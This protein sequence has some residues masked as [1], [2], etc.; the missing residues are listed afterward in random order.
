MSKFDKYF[1]WF[2]FFY[3]ILKFISIK[4]TNLNLYGDEAQY[5]LWSK[6]FSFGYFS[7]PPL[8]SWL[9][10]G[11][12]NFFGNSFFTLKSIPILIYC[13]TSYF[14]YLLVIKLYN[15]KDLAITCAIT[16]FLLPA[17][18]FSSFLL[19]TD[20]ILIF[21]WVLG[22]IQLVKIKEKQG[23]FNFFILG[24]ILGCSL[25]SK[26]AG[27]YFLLGVFCLIIFENNFK[28]I[29]LKNKFKF[30][31]TIIIMMIVISPNLYWNYQNEWLTFGHTADNASLEKISL[32]FT[33][34]I[35]FFFAQIIM[36]GP[37]LF[38]CFCFYFFKNFNLNSNEKL[39]LCFAAPPL[40]IVGIE[41]LIVRA[42]ANWAA[43]SL[44][45]FSILCVCM[46]YKF[47]KKLI[48]INNI[49]NIIVGVIL[50]I[51]ISVDYD[52]RLFD[53]IS[54]FKKFVE[55]VDT[56]N[57]TKINNIVVSDRLLFASLSYEYYSKNINL[58]STR[59]PEE[60]I[61]HHFQIN[62]FLPKDFN[63]SFLLIGN[64][65]NINYLEN[66]YNVELVGSK[67]F[68]FSKEKIKLYE[69]ILN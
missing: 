63:K 40:I 16:F 55:F 58:Y 28:L 11:I 19:S 52:S 30:F 46:I 68:P 25:L 47:N 24:L 9:I 42:H 21:F 60:K 18:S 49:I 65:V 32:N 31:F 22:L 10:G 26:Y 3:L 1:F 33:G 43:V 50:F 59:A 57:S 34:F 13:L 6:T 15:K 2:C 51:M 7:K 35:E 4:I 39:F 54:G 29:F 45:S 12:T 56:K 5:W 64:P 41:S 67:S 23:Y 38:F 36:I 62:N 69:V 48:Y 53:R 14:V 61:S 17:V 27:I 37:L 44:V 8:L 20:V 66:N